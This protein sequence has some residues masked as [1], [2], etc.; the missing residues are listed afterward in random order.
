M[1]S[2]AR[3][4]RYAYNTCPDQG[5]IAGTALPVE[6]ASFDAVADGASVRLQWQTLSET[7]NAGFSVEHSAL[8]A[9]GETISAWSEVGFVDGAGTTSEPVSYRYTVEDL[10]PGRHAFRLKQVDYDGAF[11]YSPVVEASVEVPGTHRFVI[12]GPNPFSVRTQLSLAVERE[13]RVEASLYDVQGRQVRSLVS[14]VV[15]AGESVRV[16]VDASGLPEGVYFARVIGETFTESR[17]L[18]VIK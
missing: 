7:T 1:P 16:D 9:T 10:D 18:V 14:E 13:Q 8:D 2:T 15:P 11:E 6:L 12:S 17:Q 3:I 4:T 5:V